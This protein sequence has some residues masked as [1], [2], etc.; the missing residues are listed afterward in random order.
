MN[1]GINKDNRGFTIV[2]L[3]IV[4]VI[5][6]ILAAII[7]VSY[8][9]VVK[10][11]YNTQV[12][13]GVKT[14]YEALQ[15]YYVQNHAYP[16]TSREQSGQSIAMTCIGQGYKDQYCGKVS[17]VDVYEDSVFNQQMAA[18]LKGGTGGPISN[19][20]I[21]VPGETYVGAVYGIDQV[22]PQYSPTLYARVIEYA[23]HGQNQ[24]CGIPEAHSYST[25]SGGTACEIVL[26]Q[27][28]H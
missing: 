14:Y 23:L 15:N 13:A 22:D 11:A 1:V 17:Y 9:G 6:A 7:I 2:E 4:V 21:Q 3:L 19:V 26:E 12:V 20:L 27:I 28:S 8:N 24:D 5:I 18:F 25:S 16:Q 10:N